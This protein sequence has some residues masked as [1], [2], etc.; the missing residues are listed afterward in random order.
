MTG[1]DR[2]TEL[3][4]LHVP[5]PQSGHLVE[6]LAGKS[7][8]AMAAAVYS[9]VDVIVEADGSEG[10]V[11]DVH[12]MLMSESTLH[13]DRVERF[14][15]DSVIEGPSFASREMLLSSACVAFVRCHIRADEMP[16]LQATSILRTLPGVR[17]L[18]P[19]DELQEVVLEV[20]A[21]NM[22]AFDQLIMSSIQNRGG[23]VKSTRTFLLINSMSW[24]NQQALDGAPIF[25]SVAG[26]DLPRALWLGK[27]IETDVGLDCW[28]YNDIPIATPSWTDAIDNVIDAAPLKIFLLSKDSLGS[29]ECQREFGR[30]DGVSEPSDVCCVLLPNCAVSDLPT[31]YRQR[32]CVVTAD[33]RSYPLLL[34]WIH[35]RLAATRS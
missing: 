27:R 12:R 24:R 20:V 8:V 15:A 34:D 13:V 17:R 18:L 33:F 16:M 9:G 29:E 6:Q 4:F 26:K 31:R 11:E 10:E 19:N 2:R 14:R 25:I 7:G 22:Q 23:V 5:A 32:Q 3:Y 1:G 21:P 35:R 30:A 28:T